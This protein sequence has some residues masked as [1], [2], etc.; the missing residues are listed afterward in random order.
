VVGVLA[1]LTSISLVTMSKLRKLFLLT[2]EY[3]ISITTRYIRSVAHVSAY[4][5]RR[6]TSNSD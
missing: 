6:E 2:D 3:D 1:D 4:R 5:L